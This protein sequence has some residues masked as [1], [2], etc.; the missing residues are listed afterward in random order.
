MLQQLLPIR[1]GFVS[2]GW[3]VQMRLFA[4]VL[5][6]FHAVVM[7]GLDHNTGKFGVGESICDGFDGE[8]HAIC[9]FRERTK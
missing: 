5:V 3:S 4:E 1:R 9:W 2:L 7:V 8:I 6:E